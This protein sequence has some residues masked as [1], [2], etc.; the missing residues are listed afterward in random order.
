MKYKTVVEREG[1]LLGPVDWAY[2]FR[3]HFD[4][5][6]CSV[7]RRDQE[8][9]ETVERLRK[10]VENPEGFKVRFSHGFVERDV[11]SVGMYDGWPYWRPVPALFCSGTLG[12]EWQFFYEIRELIPKAISDEARPEEPAQVRE[13]SEERD[14]QKELTWPL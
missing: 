4:N 10:I 9:R 7:E 6:G 1:E 12:G 5:M 3:Q 14:Q 8:C 13:T 2:N 11:Y